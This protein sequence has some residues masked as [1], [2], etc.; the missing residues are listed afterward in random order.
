MQV[1]LGC[2]Y[3]NMDIHVSLR[4]LF[5]SRYREG[6]AVLSISNSMGDAMILAIYIVKGEI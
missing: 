5:W 2:C 1:Q 3:V 4:K 6:L